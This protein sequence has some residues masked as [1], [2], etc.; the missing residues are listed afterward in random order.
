LAG[1]TKSNASPSVLPVTLPADSIDHLPVGVDLKRAVAGI[2]DGGARRIALHHEKAFARNSEIERLVA[3]LQRPLRELLD[4]A[5]QPRTLPRD[6]PRGLCG[7]TGKQVAK[8]RAAFLEPGRADI[9]E[10]VR[11]DRKVGLRGLQA[12]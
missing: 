8:L 4:D 9:G 7:C 1:S 2:G 12:G 6:H 3:R 10:V 5:V 11:G